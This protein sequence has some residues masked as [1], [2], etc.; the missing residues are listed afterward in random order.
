[1]N[2]PPAGYSPNPVGKGLTGSVR[3][4]AETVITTASN[5]SSSKGRMGWGSRCEQ[6]PLKVW[7]SLS[8][9]H[10]SPV[11]SFVSWD[12][13]WPMGAPTTHQ[14]QDFGVLWNLFLKELANTAMAPSSI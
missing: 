11:Q 10:S 9:N 1:M 6:I 14:I 5:V 8:S 13:I 3:Y 2:L 4:W 12:A 7:F